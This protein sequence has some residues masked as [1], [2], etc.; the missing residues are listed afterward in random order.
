MRTAYNILAEKSKGMMSFGR[1][2]HRLENSIIKMNLDYATSRK[3]AGSIPDEVI[4]F[5]Y[6]DLILSAAL[7][8]WV[9]LSL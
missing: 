2:R 8:L 6:I 5:L 7:W 3:V 4:R 1:Y 9:R